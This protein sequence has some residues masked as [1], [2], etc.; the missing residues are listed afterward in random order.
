M[1]NSVIVSLSAGPQISCTLCYVLY[2][3]YDSNYAVA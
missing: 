3:Q 1:T 2:V